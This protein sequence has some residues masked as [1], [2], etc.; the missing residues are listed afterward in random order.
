MI[1]NPE[2]IAKRTSQPSEC[3]AL[4]VNRIPQWEQIPVVKRQELTQILAGM[5]LKQVQAAGVQDERPA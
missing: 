5:L 4:A 3:Q 2:P 1:A